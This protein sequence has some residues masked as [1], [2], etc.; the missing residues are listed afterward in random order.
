MGS[1]V[2]NTLEWSIC[3]L[4]YL[5]CLNNTLEYSLTKSFVVFDKVLLMSVLKVLVKESTKKKFISRI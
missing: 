2:I 4:P 3:R 1:G 5:D